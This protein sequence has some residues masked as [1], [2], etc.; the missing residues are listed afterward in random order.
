GT[1]GAGGAPHGD[2]AP[3]RDRG[4]Q[5]GIAVRAGGFEAEVTRASGVLVGPA[6]QGGV[7]AGVVGKGLLASSAAGVEQAGVQ[8][9]LADVDPDAGGR[10]AHGVLPSSSG[11]R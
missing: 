8:G 1:G 2:G 7:A 3:R 4:D 10:L 5:P 6:D 9:V 11:M